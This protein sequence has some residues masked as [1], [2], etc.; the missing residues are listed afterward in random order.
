MIF[1]YLWM[2]CNSI[3]RLLD[4]LFFRFSSIILPFY[5]DYLCRWWEGWKHY[6]IPLFF[7]RCSGALWHGFLIA[8][9]AYQLCE[10]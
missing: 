6:H 5:F 3:A 8:L 1:C 7:H 9:F 10:F 2:F 4:D